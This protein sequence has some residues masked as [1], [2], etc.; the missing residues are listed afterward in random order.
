MTLRPALLTSRVEPAAGTVLMWWARQLGLM[1]WREGDRSW[2]GGVVDA[3]G[4]PPAG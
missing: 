1:G 2:E 3:P 4:G